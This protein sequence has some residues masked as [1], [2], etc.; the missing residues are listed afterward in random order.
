MGCHGKA[1]SATTLLCN[2][3]GCGGLAPYLAIPRA[4]TIRA[5]IATDL[6]PNFLMKRLQC[7]LTVTSAPSSDPSVWDRSLVTRMGSW[8]S[9]RAMSRQQA[10]VPLSTDR[11]APRH[12]N[13]SELDDNFAV[14]TAA[15]RHL[16]SRR[17]ISQFLPVRVIGEGGDQRWDC[18]YA[19]TVSSATKTPVRLI[20]AS[21]LWER[22]LL[23]WERLH[24]PF[25]CMKLVDGDAN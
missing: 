23:L 4:A 6:A 15:S 14:T 9:M 2:Y 13:R 20:F 1:N 5:S 7:I 21:A 22:C 17:T 3:P 11:F 18:F 16:G 10:R 25:I 8:W 19:E 24:L 12:V